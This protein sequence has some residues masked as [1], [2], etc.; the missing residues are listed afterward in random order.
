MSRARER[1]LLLLRRIVNEAIQLNF[2]FFFGSNRIF[3]RFFLVSVLSLTRNLQVISFSLN[4]YFGFCSAFYRSINEGASTDSNPFLI[5][6]G[7]ERGA[8]DK[9]KSELKKSK[10]NKTY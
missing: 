8:Q 5:M 9:T 1:L 7:T 10:K 6:S 4:I 2:C 3:I